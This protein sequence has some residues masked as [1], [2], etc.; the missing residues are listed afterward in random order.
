MAA[1]KAKRPSS[2][3]RTASAKTPPASLY[4]GGPGSGITLPPYFKPTPSVVS[5]SNFFPLVEELGP[6]EMRI[7]FMGTCPFPPKRNQAATCIM[8]EL[9]N[10]DRFFFDFGPGC[11]RNIA[12]FQV[13]VQDVNDIFITHLHVDHYGELPYLYAFAPWAAR[14][15]PLRV[16]GPSGR[17]RD[18]GIAHVVEKMKEM[19][20]W[21]TKAFGLGPV[22]EGYEVEVN[23]FDYTD[24]NG[25]CFD[26]NGVTIRHWRRSHNMDGASAYRLDW[27]GLS[28]VWTGDGRPDKLTAEFAA[29]VDVFVTEL[30][31]DLGKLME[32][33]TGVPQ[34]IYNA[35]IDMVHTDHYATGYVINQVGPR[36]GMVT[37]MA[38]DHEVINEVIAGVRTHWKGLFCLGVPDGVVVNVTRDAI[39]SRQAVLPDSGNFK[40]PA[41]EDELRQ[42]FGGEIPEAMRIPEPERTRDE[43]LSPAVR[44][45]E[46]SPSEFVP[47]DVFR[48]LIEDMGAAFGP[49][50]GKDIP[51]EMLVG[52]KNAGAAVG[53]FTHAVRSMASALNLLG[54]GI[55]GQLLPES[56]Q[57]DQLQEALRSLTGLVADD[58]AAV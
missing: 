7:S 15:K 23:E 46:I 50:M 8:V 55:A 57:K 40:R 38:Y 39:W 28:F 21:H 20:R 56:A 17:K 45:I 19:T 9:G 26:K 51:V 34:Q 22:G 11:L 12:A 48:P 4:G 52:A 10:G 32:V 1:A 58:H 49:A 25:I 31:P 42:M 36:M 3:A 2:P 5:A 41:T 27:N 29:G 35:T 16:H 18:E 14:W 44:A 33:K 43:L 37:H 13:P 53:E 47:A 30:Q 54:A 6:D 24:D